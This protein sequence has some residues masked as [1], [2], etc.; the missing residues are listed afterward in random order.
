MPT[1]TIN[2][3]EY[4]DHFIDEQ[5]DAGKYQD[6]NEVLRAGLRLLEKQTQTENLQQTLLIKLATQGFAPLDQGEGIALAD[7]EALKCAI[8]GIGRRVGGFDSSTQ[9]K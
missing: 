7:E 1:R 3:T 8:A 4:F 6:A 2:L 5:V 9:A